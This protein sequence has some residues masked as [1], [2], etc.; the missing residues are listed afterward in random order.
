MNTKDLKVLN[1]KA[2]NN[3]ELSKGGI[4]STEH[5]KP[6]IYY[7]LKII[8]KVWTKSKDEFKDE[9]IKILDEY[10]QELEYQ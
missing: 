1:R 5:K 2:M 3:F 8:R 4:Y 9:M 10:I 7:Q 6:T